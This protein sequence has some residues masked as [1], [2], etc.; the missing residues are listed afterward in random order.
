M[1]FATE[2]TLRGVC[3]VLA[4]MP[5][6]TALGTLRLTAA[7]VFSVAKAATVGALIRAGDVLIYFVFTKANFDGFR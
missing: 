2:G 3:A 1:V 6:L 4:G 7:K 5:F